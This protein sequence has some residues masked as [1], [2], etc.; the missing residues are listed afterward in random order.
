MKTTTESDLTE[1]HATIKLGIDADGKWF[2]VTRQLDGVSRPRRNV[3]ID[4][5]R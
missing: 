4:S 5:L 3:R 2:Y 1:I